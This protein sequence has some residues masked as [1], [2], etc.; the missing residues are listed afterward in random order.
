MLQCYM[1]HVTC[2]VKD[3]A[4]RIPASRG[5]GWTGQE[6]LTGGQEGDWDR[7]AGAGRIG[8]NMVVAVVFAVRSTQLPTFLLLF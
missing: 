7:G 4:L 3:F 6:A 8:E 1:L 5:R 2:Y